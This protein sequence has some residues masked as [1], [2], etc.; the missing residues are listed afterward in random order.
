MVEVLIACDD[1]LQSMSSLHGTMGK[2]REVIGGQGITIVGVKSRFAEASVAGEWRDVQ[3][4][5]FF[6]SDANKHVCEIQ[7]MHTFM[8]KVRERAGMHDTYE[9]ARNAIELLAATGRHA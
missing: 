1:Q 8:K 9:N 3:I 7:I 2:I 4:K 5:F 6:N